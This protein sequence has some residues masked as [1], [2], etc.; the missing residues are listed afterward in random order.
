MKKSLVAAVALCAAAMAPMAAQAEAYFKG[1]TV[2]LLVGFSPGGG[3]DQ[4][5]R[6]VAE[7]LDDHIPGNP[8]VIVENM[9]GS[10]SILA[11][12][13]YVTRVEPNGE[14]LMVGTGQLLMRIMLGLQGSRAELGQ[15]DP[16]MAGPVGRVTFA[17]ADLG[18]ENPADI[19]AAADRLIHASAGIMASIDTLLGLKVLGTEIRAITGYEGK[20]ETLLA[21]ERGEANIDGQTMP[22][23]TGKVQPMIDEGKAVPL[24]SQGFID[25]KGKLVADPSVPDLPTVADVYRSLNNGA[26]PEGPAWS[27]YMAMTGATVSLGRVL[28]VHEDAPDAAVE[29]LEQGIASMLADPVFL[30]EIDASLNGYAPY[31]GEE[32]EAA[33][34]ATKAMSEDDKTW[35]Q[36]FLA[37]AYGARFE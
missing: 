32:L 15:Y 31:A 3:T 37:R 33:I 9:P 10:G 14:T 24:F 23:Y 36:D 26:D 17:A 22:N 13:H 19:P 27:A 6:V 20:S 4:F 12:N 29:A 2:T 35:L 30:K 5:A 8:A 18:I 11:S 16:L 1:K 28:M 21:F 25:G 34:N 7:H